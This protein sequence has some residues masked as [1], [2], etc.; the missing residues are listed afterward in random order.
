MAKPTTKPPVHAA[1]RPAA[2]PAQWLLALAPAWS[3]A[4]FVA[5]AVFNLNA[6]PSGPGREEAGRRVL[7]LVLLSGNALALACWVAFGNWARVRRLSPEMR[8]ASATSAVLAM[9]TASIWVLARPGSSWPD[10]FLAGCF[11]H[12]P[13][14]ALVF[15]LAWFAA[16]RLASPGRAT[17]LCLGLAEGILL[18]QLRLLDAAEEIQFLVSPSLMIVAAVLVWLVVFTSTP[19]PARPLPTQ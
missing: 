5:L 10:E 19:A 1:S 17:L 15:T 6:S 4:L 3:L 7:R 8:R 18:L 11:F 12:V 2:T 16:R 9:G 13:T 14:L